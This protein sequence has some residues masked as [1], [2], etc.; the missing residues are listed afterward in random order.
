MAK[1]RMRNQKLAVDK[2]GSIKS[3]QDRLDSAKPHI[4]A[5]QKGVGGGQLREPLPLYVKAPCEH[6]IEGQNNAAI[7]LG[8]D[9][10]ASRLS[11]YGGKGDT[12]CGMIDLCVGR[13][14]YSPRA[15]T[16]SGESIWVDPDMKVDS[17][18]VYLSQKTDVDKNFGLK[19]GVVG[20]TTSKSAVVLKADGVR[21]VAREGIKLVTRTDAKNSQGGRVASVTGIDLIAGNNDEDMQPFVK[22]ANM[23]SAM[24]RVIHHIDKLN[25]IVD[26]L[27][28][29]QFSFNAAL[30]SHFHFSPFFGIPT[31]PSPTA[32]AAGIVCMANHMSQ[33][34]ASLV[35]H[36]MNLQMCEKTYFYASGG[37]YINSRYNHVN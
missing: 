31:S 26:S 32:A 34:K 5:G 22:G 3:V 37:K 30:V 28:M 13:M 10:P 12:Q 7:V 36:K 19:S 8:R 25:G 6:V 1:R 29:Y 23:V 11:G 35:M 2:T 27:L 16:G 17:A 14:A 15:V 9:R 18:R 24:R 20:N 4:Q 33:T 21:L